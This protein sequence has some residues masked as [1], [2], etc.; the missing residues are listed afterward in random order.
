MA[1]MP[2]VLQY[3]V[4]YGLP[5]EALWKVARAGSLHV[6]DAAPDFSLTRLD[7]K[8]PKSKELKEEPVR[9]SV[10]RGARPVV[11]IFGSYT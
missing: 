1:K 5:T 10:Y 9:L 11:L 8:D 3:F 2:R 7:T 4:Y 6:G